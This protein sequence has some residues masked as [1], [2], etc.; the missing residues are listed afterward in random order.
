MAI[1]SQNPLMAPLAAKPLATPAPAAAAAPVA[2]AAPAP[3]QLA[4]GALAGLSNVA[5]STVTPAANQMA[6]GLSASLPPPVAAPAAA[7]PPPTNPAPAN[8]NSL[9]AYNQGGNQ[10]QGP[11]NS[12][13]QGGMT[14]A[15][16]NTQLQGM[17]A[18][19]QQGQGWGGGYRGPQQNYMQPQPMPVQPAAP[20]APQGSVEQQALNGGGIDNKQQ[21]S[22]F[23]TALGQARAGSNNQFANGGTPAAAAP[24]QPLVNMPGA[25]APQQAST[26]QQQAPSQSPMVQQQLA[27]DFPMNGS[28]QMAPGLS[29]W[30]Q[31]NQNNPPN[32]IANQQLAQDFPMNGSNQMAPGL[33]A[34][35]Y[36]PAPAQTSVTPTNQQPATPASQAR[37]FQAANTTPLVSDARAKEAA[38]AEGFKVGVKAAMNPNGLSVNLPPSMTPASPGTVKGAA[39]PAASGIGAYAPVPG[40]GPAFTPVRDPATG[41]PITP[42]QA[43]LTK[44]PAATP[45]PYVEPY[46][47]ANA[48]PAAA[49][50]ASTAPSASSPAVSDEDNKDVVGNAQGSLQDFM[51]QIG[52]HNYTYKNPER[53]GEGTFT[54]PM[55]Q[56]LERTKLGKQAVVETPNGKAVDYQ[57]LGGV[58][59]AALSVIN[60]QQQRMQ[61]QLDEMRGAARKGRS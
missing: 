15:Q 42:S 25:Q 1:V 11:S 40:A 17:A 60:R 6:A 41:Q 58:N 57:R 35:V 20:A 37:A 19:P 3:N 48:T 9:N 8:A 10:G 50:I 33:A 22:N 52:A 36:S 21:I 23:L 27:Q 47:Q 28:N 4:P 49:P 13:V 38:K 43:F 51:G 34:S 46:A 55:A 56:E 14:A 16:A 45:I 44:A 61:A 2:A 31:A 24:T 30:L 59:L 5:P 7:P 53:D 12:G 39:F 18:A 26:Y 29:S 32:Q 54:S